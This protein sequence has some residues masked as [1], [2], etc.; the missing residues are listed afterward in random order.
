MQAK[1]GEKDIDFVLGQTGAGNNWAKKRD[2]TPR[3]GAKFID[4]VLE[5]TGAGNN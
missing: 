3:G 2:I 5:Q 1:T 4:F